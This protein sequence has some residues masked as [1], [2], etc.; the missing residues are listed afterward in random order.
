MTRKEQHKARKRKE[1][2]HYYYGAGVIC[3]LVYVA[4]NSTRIAAFYKS[5]VEEE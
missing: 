5:K 4:V 1:K 3:T 2:G